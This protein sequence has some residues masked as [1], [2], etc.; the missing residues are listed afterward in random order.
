MKIK[1][2]LTGPLFLLLINLI[3]VFVWFKKGLIF[4]G[5]ESGLPFYNLNKSF[6]LISSTWYDSAGG[7]PNVTSSARIPFFWLLKTLFNW[8]LSGVF[9]QALTFFILIAIGTFAVYFL[10]KVTLFDELKKKKRLNKSYRFVPLIGAIFYLFNPFSMLQVWGRGLYVQ[11][12]AFAY[13]PVFLLFF[14]VGLKRRNYL[15]SVLAVLFSF[16]LSTALVSVSY[17]LSSWLLVSLY[18]IY[19]LKKNST[20]KKDIIFSITFY[21]LT[22][23]SWVAIH[24]LWLLPFLINSRNLVST[25][26]GSL[27]HNLGSLRGVSRNYSLSTVLRLLHHFLYKD[28]IYGEV[29]SS[30]FFK[31]MSFLIPAVALFSLRVFKKT[32]HFK[33]YLSLFLISLFVVLGSNPPLGFAFEW[34]FTT[35]PPLQVFR[36]P[37]EKM[38]LVFLLAYTPF[39]SI[40]CVKVSLFV[41]EFTKRKFS[42]LIIKPHLVVVLILFLVSGVYVWPMWKGIFAGG[43]K[44]NVWVKVPSYYEQA[45]DWLNEKEGEFRLI[46]FPLNPGDGI[47]YTWENSYQ[48]TDPSEFLFS[49]HSIAKNVAFNKPYYNVLLERFGKLAKN[50][51]GP[52]PDITNSKFKSEEF[53]Q[54]LEKLNVK[55][56]LLHFDV[57]TQ[58]LRMD[59]A[60]KMEE[61]LSKQKNIKKLQS[62]GGLDIYEVNKSPEIDLIFSEEAEI[63]YARINP[64]S[65]E[66]I[67]NNEDSKLTKL[68][69]LDLFDQNWMAF[70]NGKILEHTKAFSYAN[71]WIIDESDDEYR[72]VIKYKPQDY[73]ETGLKI[74]LISLSLM[75]VFLAISLVRKKA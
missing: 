15:Y 56:I 17:I 5:G 8:G 50:A 54:E 24:S 64:A 75:S 58:L 20:K 22:L 61:Y 68:N 67:V 27:E 73:F 2:R 1:K 35:L 71:S 21:F 59:S 42:N 70:R 30:F 25:S 31:A 29:Y 44:I 28:K 11:F 41:S 52:D 69:F 49:K 66:V 4:A 9:L 45:N 47:K 55:Y 23:V 63:K 65:Y 40:G 10:L 33:F 32:S 39:F 43:V 18:L 26:L 62:F 16:L 48:G 36:N 7:F 60:E 37:Y 74:S 51:Y 38:G 46:H 13:L 57:D 6:N 3:L 72:V 34:I 12:F 53:Y 19:Y 14:I